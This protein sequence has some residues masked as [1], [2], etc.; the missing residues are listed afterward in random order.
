VSGPE[1]NLGRLGC[2][3]RGCQIK[4]GERMLPIQHV[5]KTLHIMVSG[6]KYIDD[7]KQN[8]AFFERV[9][10]FGMERHSFKSN[11]LV[12]DVLQG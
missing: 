10:A 4:C 9:L 6:M 11:A 3:C 1:I 8:L 5:L 7:T 12:L 2:Q